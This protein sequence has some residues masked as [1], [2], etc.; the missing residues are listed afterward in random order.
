[1]V[2]PGVD[3][4]SAAARPARP[5]RCQ[6]D[7]PKRHSRRDAGFAGG[8]HTVPR[9]P[10]SG[11]ALAEELLEALGQV[12]RVEAGHRVGVGA[13]SV[14]AGGTERAGGGRRATGGSLLGS[15]PFLRSALGGVA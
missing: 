14:R 13:L 2:P 3:N 7:E 1:M 11:S 12:R 6:R 9:P 15:G 4:W 10:W 5:C 8:E